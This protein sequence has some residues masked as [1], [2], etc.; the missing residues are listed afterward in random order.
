[1]APL[2]RTSSEAKESLESEIALPGAQTTQANNAAQYGDFTMQKALNFQGVIGKKPVC[3]RTLG[4]GKHRAQLVG[5]SPK[6][7]TA[8]QHSSR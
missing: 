4:L 8:Y 3:E 7:L 1:M 2:V 5:K 6:C